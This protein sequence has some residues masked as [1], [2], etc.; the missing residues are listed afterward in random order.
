MKKL[1]P[2]IFLALA[3]ALT[4]CAAQ[5]DSE[6]PVI[7]ETAAPTQEAAPEPTPEPFPLSGLKIGIDAGHQKKG[8]SDLEPQAPGSDTKKPKVTSGTS[9]R[10]SGVP[11]YQVNLD[12][13]LLL[14]VKLTALGAEVVM[15]RTVNEVDISNSERATMMNDAGVDLCIRIHADGS[16]NASVHGAS[17][18]VPTQENNPDIVDASVAAGE[19]I[20]ESYV[21]ATGAKDNGLSPRRDMTGF[22]WSTVPVCL[23]ELGYMTNEDEDLLLT[24][25]EYQEKCA[26][27]LA[28][29]VA[30]WAERHFF[31]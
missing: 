27:G 19:I 31:S 29:G 11:E 10:F 6:S 1:I 20:L 8:N 22:N 13:A 7:E 17:M 14:E 30:A 15:V 2:T 5:R 16:E 23:I 21:T 12:V 18:L 3:V 28:D 26:Q 24:D 25:A 9:G 4:G